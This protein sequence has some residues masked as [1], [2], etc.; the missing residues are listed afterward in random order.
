VKD[1]YLRGEEVKKLLGEHQ[2]RKVDHHVRIWLLLNLEVWY[3][4]YVAGQTAQTVRG[5]LSTTLPTLSAAVS[6]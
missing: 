6:P 1:G 3:R 4:M 5:D 2:A